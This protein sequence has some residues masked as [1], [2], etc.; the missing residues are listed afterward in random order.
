MIYRNIDQSKR[1]Y[2]AWYTSL[3]ELLS[4]TPQESNL[5]LIGEGVVDPTR[6][7]KNRYGV[8]SAKELD[9]LILNGWHE[10]VGIA[11]RLTVELETPRLK[12][13]R[14]VKRRGDFGDSI[15][16]QAVYGGSIDRAWETTRR[17]ISISES[18]SA[19][20]LAVELSCSWNY[21]AHE[22]YWT[23]AAAIKLVDALIE[24]G[25]SVQ[26][27]GYLSSTDAFNG[28]ISDAE[29]CFTAKEYTEV[30][31]ISKLMTILGHAAF[32]RYYGFR[33]YA[34]APLVVKRNLGLPLYG[35]LP[36]MIL[37][38]EP[39]NSIIRVSRVFS[40]SAAQQ[41]INWVVSRLRGADAA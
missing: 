30:A 1:R 12:N 18:G 17:E 32:Y 28:Q 6:L 4:E 36:Q 13:V 5:R 16:M 24:S 26:I 11:D 7:P 27:I 38:R 40:Q 31:D 14:R 29:I 10:G 15:D 2:Q 21:M 20:T 23:G 8:G 19:I 34:A 41:M 37:D 22:L 33:A 35:V 3:A 9:Q 25:R 39:V